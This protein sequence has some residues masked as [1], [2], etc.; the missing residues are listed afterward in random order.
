MHPVSGNSIGR[1]RW[2][3]CAATRPGWPWPWSLRSHRAAAAAPHGGV[4]DAG[5]GHGLVHRRG[6]GRPGCPGRQPA[7]GRPGRA[8][9]PAGPGGGGRVRAADPDRRPHYLPPVVLGRGAAG[10]RRL[11]RLLE[12]AW[13]PPL[14]AVNLGVLLLAAGP[15][16]GWASRAG[17]RLAGLGSAASCRWPPP[18]WP[19]GWST[20]PVRAAPPADGGG[21]RPS[22]VTP[23]RPLSRPGGRG[24]RRFR[25]QGARR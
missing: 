3:G 12:L 5:G 23:W 22:A 11:T 13:P 1:W 14:A 9:G 18:R 20:T 17:W 25:R 2:P 4:L 6:R 16:S 15:T 21:R 7:G 24:G 8:A 10:N 19:G